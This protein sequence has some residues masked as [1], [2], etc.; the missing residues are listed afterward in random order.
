MVPT[1][2]IILSSAI[3]FGR[4]LYQK[5]RV[6]QPIHWRK[7]QKMAIQLLSI[8]VLYL[9]LYIPEMM[10]EFVYLCGVSEKTGADFVVYADFFSY[11]V[12]LL[13]PFVC[14]GSLPHL[15]VKLKNLFPCWRRQRRAIAPEVFRI[16]QTTGGPLINE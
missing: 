2:V 10:L 8:S 16:Q 11:Y 9:I 13:F 7:H 15:K 6:R 5:K 12:Y 14:A 3:L 4:I 1:F